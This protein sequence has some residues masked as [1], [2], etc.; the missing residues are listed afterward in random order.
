[1]LAYVGKVGDAYEPFF[2]SD[3]LGLS[4]I[5]ISEDMYIV[6]KEVAEEYLKEQI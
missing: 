6:S 3:G 5:E 1:M 2:F 4:D